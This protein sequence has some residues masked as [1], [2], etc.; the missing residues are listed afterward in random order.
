[1]HMNSLSALEPLGLV[2]LYVGAGKGKT[3]AAAGL[4][5][6][7]LGAGKSVLFCQFL[8]GRESGELKGLKTLGAVLARAKCGGKFLFQMSGEEREQ[9]KHDHEDCFGEA[10]RRVLAGGFDVVVLDEIIDA[11]NAG[12]IPE[13]T[14]LSLIKKR[15][16]GVELVL[17]GRDPS[18]AFCEAADYHTE[19]ICK[20]HPYG[21]G[22]SAREGIEY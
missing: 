6:R 16:A 18:D 10:M 4:A 17:T 8:K 7:A 22:V 14:V 13:K 11:V 2:H 9:L 12:L 1:M 21:C 5:V 3:T 15:P 20:K 19:F